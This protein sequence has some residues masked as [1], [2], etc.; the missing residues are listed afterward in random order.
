MTQKKLINPVKPVIKE[1][2]VPVEPVITKIQFNE[3]M[4][5]QTKLWEDKMGKEMS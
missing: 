5:K 3:E 4:Q 1:K 2:E